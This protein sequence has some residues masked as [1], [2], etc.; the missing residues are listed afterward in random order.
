MP[1]PVAD[2]VKEQRCARFME[3]QAAI[4][5]KRLPTKVGKTLQVP[6]D[7]IT[8]QGAVGRSAA[9]APE[10]DGRVYLEN[11]LQL[12]P[13]PRLPARVTR[14]DCHDLWGDL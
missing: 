1:D 5:T 9:D 13:G 3:K 11:A 12:R 8:P 14:A 10:L 4:G 2:E 7:E 6:I